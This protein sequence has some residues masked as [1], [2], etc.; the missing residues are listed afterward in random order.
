[1]RRSIDRNVFVTSQ[2]G[3][4]CFSLRGI[5]T[6][7]LKQII[8]IHSYLQLIILPPLT[9]A[10]DYFMPLAFFMGFSFS[11]VFVRL[12]F[13]H[14]MRNHGQNFFY[15]LTHKTHKGREKKN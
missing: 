12:T 7:A 4:E 13:L 6:S 10:F 11:A 9:F 5:Q 1:M 3:C 14:I 8:N 15:S 2:S